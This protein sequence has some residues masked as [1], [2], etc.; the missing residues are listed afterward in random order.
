MVEKL[1]AIILE[2]IGLGKLVLMVWN[3][4][5]KFLK[6]KVDETQN[7]IDNE[8]LELVHTIIKIWTEELK[9]E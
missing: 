5:Y 1:I 4:L 6:Q 2:K 7:N 8:V 9:E 3:I